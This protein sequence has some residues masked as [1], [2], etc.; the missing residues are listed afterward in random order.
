[1]LE[2]AG[3]S[4]VRFSPMHD[5]TLPDVEMLYLGGG[6]PEIYAGVLQRIATDAR[7]SCKFAARGGVIYAECGGLMYLTRTLRDFDGTAYDMVGNNSSRNGYEP[8]TNDAW[9]IE[10]LRL[11]RAGILGDDR[12]AHPRT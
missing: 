12:S 10:S 7:Q 11:T 8:D 2:A 1:L 3:G 6:Y 5:S 4:I 9:D